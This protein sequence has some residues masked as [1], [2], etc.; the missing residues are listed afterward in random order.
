[1]WLLS[2]SSAPEALAVV[3]GTGPF[4]GQGPH[5]SRRTPGAKT[6]TGC[7]REIVLVTDCGRAVWAVVYQRTPAPRG[8][9]ASRGR[10]GQTAPTR[11]I[12]RN[13]LFRNLGAGLSSNLIREAV[14]ATYREWIMRYGSLPTERLRTEIDIN[15]VRSTNPGCCYL[16]A[17]WE[18][19]RVVRGKLYL[20]APN[21]VNA[22]F[23]ES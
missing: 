2:S 5:Y 13:M 11:Y 9:G 23:I 3:D 1:M 7:G 8:T 18:R 22:G 20:Y 19:D 16:K 12:W 21:I 15:A 6:F 17:G 10:E 14:D 4:V